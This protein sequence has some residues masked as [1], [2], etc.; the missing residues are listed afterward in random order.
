MRLTTLVKGALLTCAIAWSS[1]LSVQSQTYDLSRDFSV[2]SNPNGVWSYGYAAAIGGSYSN[3]LVSRT[4]EA[5]SYPIWSWSYNGLQSPDLH[6]NAGT[7]TFN[8]GGGTFPPG[9]VWVCP[10]PDG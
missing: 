6:F 10:G 4:N 1:C 9:M 8:G 5:P 7:N 2:R 3:L